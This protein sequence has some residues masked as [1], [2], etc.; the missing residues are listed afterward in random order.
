MRLISRLLREDSTKDPGAAAPRS[1]VGLSELQTLLP[2]ANDHFQNNNLAAA[3]ASFRRVLELDPRCAQAYYMLSAIVIETGDI[4]S[5]IRL[6]H[7]AI[8][9][10]PTNAAFHAGLATIYASQ[11]RLAEAIGA[12]EEV[13]RLTPNSP[14]WRLELAATLIKAGRLPDALAAYEAGLIAGSPDAKAYFDLG[15]AL[16]KR[17]RMT[18]AEQ[19]FQRAAAMAPESAGIQ[20]YLSIVRRDQD[21]PVE[22]EAA[23]RAATGL[24]PDM[25]QGWFALGSALTRQGRHV[26]AVEHYRQ[27]ISLMPEY[28]AAWD[29]LLSTMI[30]SEHW[31]ARQV[32]DAHVEWGKRFPKSAPMPIPSLRRA[33]SHRIRVGYLSGDFRHHSVSFFIDPVLHNHDTTRFEIFCYYSDPREESVTRRFRGY[34][35]NW[36]SVSEASDDDLEKVLRE[37]G[38]DI[39]VELSGH[40]SGHRLPVLARRGAPVQATY[41]GYP[42][43][44]GLAAIDYRITDARADPPG[45]ADELSVE[46]LVRLPETFLCYSPPATSGVPR[47]APFRRK[48]YITFG[49]F[50]NFPKISPT[51]IALWA[52]IVSSVPDARLFIKSHGLQD[53]GLRALLLQRLEEAGTDSDRVSI[54]LPTQSHRDH[55]EAYGEVDVALDTFPYHGTTT[56]LDALWMGVPVITL[57]GDRH[58]SRVGVSILST[59]RLT[60]LVAQT[61]D[62]YLDAAIELAGDVEKLER[63]RASLRERLAGSAL[64]DGRRF[65]ANL[66]A[67]YLQMLNKPG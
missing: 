63:L 3:S 50:N 66:E 9:L 55:M 22:A 61:P 40:S 13:V 57:A 8:N 15:E 48:G 6:A 28:D 58:A 20:F 27:A 4:E 62:Q 46:K 47:T 60:E 25:P 16:L 43:T 45:E 54:A 67:A 33:G 2:R 7:L 31:S 12:Y 24:A 32:R 29:G 30:Y 37:D 14:E 64:T 52:K 49:S 5:A 11:Q 38:L 39:L 18:E 36:R 65:T 35:E 42:N 44:T 17:R 23:A 1:E 26:E 10:Q 19:A 53:P 51:C 41:L 56:T 59:L 34:V 21:R